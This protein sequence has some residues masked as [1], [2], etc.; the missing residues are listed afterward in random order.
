VIQP[1]SAAPPLAP[2]NVAAFLA[3]IAHSR[4]YRGQIARVVQL[5]EQEARFGELSRPLPLALREALDTLGIEQLYTHQARCVETAREGKSFVVVTA[6]A[7]GKTLCYNLPILEHRLQEP[8]A[9]ASISIPTKALAQDQL[10]GLLRLQE[11]GDMA[12]KCG[13]YDGDTPSST[14]SALRDRADLILTN[15]DMLHSGI[16][17]SHAKWSHFFEKL[18]FV[19]IDE[20]HTY[21]GIFG[22]NVANVL[23]RLNRI[24][25]HY[26]SQPQFICASAT[27]ANPQELCERLCGTSF[28]L[29]EDDGAPR[30]AKHFVLWN[31]PLMDR[32]TMNR[33]LNRRV[34]QA[35]QP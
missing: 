32:I 27:I 4:H 26:G 25:Q 20:V 3:D 23:R 11:A 5:P 34:T 33:V 14:R 15:P 30:G 1:F 21:R 13:T 28:D 8:G 24:C 18:R 7:S 10:R 31:P 19:V 22:S 29:V 6:T 9:K 35:A 16:L 2:F 12:F 17:P